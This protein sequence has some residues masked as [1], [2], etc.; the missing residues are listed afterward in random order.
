MFLPDQPLGNLDLFHRNFTNIID[1]QKTKA[2][3][4]RH[5]DDGFVGEFWFYNLNEVISPASLPKVSL[6]T[7]F[8]RVGASPRVL[9]NCLSSD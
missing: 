3:T 5:K 8:S 9:L 4:K 2:E 1:A 7:H 6:T